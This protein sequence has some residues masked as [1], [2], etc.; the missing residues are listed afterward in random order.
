MKKIIKKIIQKE[1]IKFLLLGL[2]IIATVLPILLASAYSFFYA[3]DFSEGVISNT[4]QNY[5]LWELLEH[6]FAF[7]RRLWHDWLGFYFSKFM[8]VLLSALNGGGLLKLRIVMSG[9]ALLF[10]LSFC[11]F[12]YALSK[13][14]ISS[15][16]YRIGIVAIGCIGVLGFEAWEQAFYWFNGAM[17]YSLPLSVSMLALALVLL[18]PRLNKWNMILICVCLFCGMGG[19]L[20]ISGACC[21][22]LIMV[23]VKLIYK[24]GFRYQYAC[25][26]I[27]TM[28]GC[29]L[30]AVAPGNFARHSIADGSGVHIFRAV[31]WSLDS[32]VKTTQWLIIDT[33]FILFVILAFWIGSKEGKKTRI[34]EKYAYI[35]ICFNLLTP[36]AAA[37]PVCLGYSGAG[38]PNR[39]EFILVYVLVL[40]TVNIAIIVGKKVAT[41]IS[42]EVEQQMALFGIM[43]V[44]I[45]PI[46]SEGWAVTS[47]V[48]YKTMIALA[49]GR[50][51]KYYREVNRI[52][53]TCAENK[54]KDVF[55]YSL[56]QEV[57]VFSSIYLEE[58]PTWDVNVEF[59]NYFQN[60]SVQ[61]VLNDV[62]HGEDATYVRISPSSFV[63]DMSYVTIVNT[64]KED[65]QII[66]ILEPLNENLVIQIPANL[67]GKIG[68][69]VFADS[70]G[71]ER[72]LQREIEY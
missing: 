70:E 39:C 51:Q 61:L 65:T 1:N 20:M 28:A 8:E 69:Y 44:M 67:S 30:N 38:L 25:L 34:D 37:Y 62:F 60:R 9:N 53:E 13:E 22:L 3:D 68:I 54:G 50:I 31:I 16:L 24:N 66:Q 64:L 5:S 56:P 12:L 45:M 43:L 46:R 58:D 29:V 41:K 35:M 7:S 6:S 10:I 18:W 47:F 71:K 26:L 15:Q 33:P 32:I 42:L 21:W 23:L 17:N 72:V 11:L 49:D 14:E 57:D 48:P 63:E 55:I 40:S 36:F 4:R 52:Y 27:V 2:I 59:A 19:S